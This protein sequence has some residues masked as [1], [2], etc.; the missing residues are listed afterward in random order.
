[1]ETT[2]TGPYP[3]AT[4]LSCGEEAIKPQ[5]WNFMVNVPWYK[6]VTNYNHYYIATGILVNLTK[7]PRGEITTGHRICV[8]LW[9]RTAQK[10]FSAVNFYFLTS[11]IL[12][13]RKPTAARW[14]SPHLADSESSPPLSQTQPV[15]GGRQQ[16][17]TH[18]HCPPLSHT[19]LL[20]HCEKQ[21][22]TLHFTWLLEAQSLQGK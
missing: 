12:F 22:W 11:I 3:P 21:N 5:T 1:M 9:V 20:L 18:Y 15:C 14:L 13:K 19:K 2:P 16:L 4:S 10:L 7:P 8:S 6:T 17:Y